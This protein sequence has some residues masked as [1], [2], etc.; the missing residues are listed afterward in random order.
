[1]TTTPRFRFGNLALTALAAVLMASGCVRLTPTEE[2]ALRHNT[3]TWTRDGSLQGNVRFLVRGAPG[4]GDRFRPELR[5]FVL[6]DAA[7]SATLLVH[8]SDKRS[9]SVLPSHYQ[10]VAPEATALRVLYFVESRNSR[11]AIVADWQKLPEAKTIN[12]ERRSPL[13]T[14]SY[15]LWGLPR[16]LL[17]VPFTMARRLGYGDSLEPGDLD[18]TD[19]YFMAGAGIGGATAAVL[20]ALSAVSPPG[21]AIVVAVFAGSGAMA[22]GMHFAPLVTEPVGGLGRLIGDRIERPLLRAGVHSTDYFPNWRFVVHRPVVTLGDGPAQWR[23][24]DFE[25]VDP[26]DY[27]LPEPAP[28]TPPPT[29]A[30]GVGLDGG[31]AGRGDDLRAPT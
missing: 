24:V 28:T 17:D 20:W 14:A 7:T 4:F 19:H 15:P 25:H 8:G 29:P 16:D 1:M 12:Y 2:L 5:V 30:A 26:D 10:G 27:P 13:L 31:A 22:L 18:P 23:V 11:R 3:R 6:D 21:A 9:D